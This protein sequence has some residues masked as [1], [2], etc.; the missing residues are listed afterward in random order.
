MKGGERSSHT[1]RF[2]IFFHNC[3]G[4]CVI[5][6][7]LWKVCYKY[8]ISGLHIIISSHFLLVFYR[9]FSGLLPITR[10]YVL[11]YAFLLSSGPNDHPRPR[12]IKIKQNKE[13]W[14]KTNSLHS[15][16]RELLRSPVSAETRAVAGRRERFILFP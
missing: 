13:I 8:L 15:K 3:W 7:D 14:K 11:I 2:F 9:F 4:L 6:A 10:F 1:S 5:D 16:T 12:G